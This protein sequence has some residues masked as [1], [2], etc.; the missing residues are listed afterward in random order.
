MKVLRTARAEMIVCREAFAVAE[1]AAYDSFGLVRSLDA[2]HDFSR[3][4]DALAD[5]I[6]TFKHASESIWAFRAVD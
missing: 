4:S 2:L 6:Y 1:A 5:A 3:A